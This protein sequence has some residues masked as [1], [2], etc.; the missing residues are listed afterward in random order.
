[1]DGD[2]LVDIVGR[3]LPLKY[4]PGA[5]TNFVVISGAHFPRPMQCGEVW[6]GTDIIAAVRLLRV[7]EQQKWKNQV[8]E[9]DIKDYLQGEPI[10]LHTDRS[11]TIVWGGAPGEEPALEVLAEGKLK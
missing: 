11:T 1:K 8:T 2:H 5:K 4:E 9:I 3:L 10:R 7:I 6:E